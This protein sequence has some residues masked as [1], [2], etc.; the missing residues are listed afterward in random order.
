M[1]LQQR[2]YGKYSNLTFLIEGLLLRDY[3]C[4]M[5]VIILHTSV[6]ANGF[7]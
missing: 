4:I 1:F 2:L 3:V 7:L 5:A 6:K